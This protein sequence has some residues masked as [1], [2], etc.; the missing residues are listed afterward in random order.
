M[1]G[2]SLWYEN[3]SRFIPGAFSARLD[4]IDLACRGRSTAIACCAAPGCFMKTSA[5]RPAAKS[6]AVLV[7]ISS[8]K[9][10]ARRRRQQLPVWPAPVARALRRRQLMPCATRRNLHRALDTLVLQRALLNP[11]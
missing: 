10:P 4:L 1:T 7:L 2:K 3:D 11:W 8:S 6:P 9:R 5:A